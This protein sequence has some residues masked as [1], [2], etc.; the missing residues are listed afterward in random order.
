MSFLLFPDFLSGINLLG[1]CRVN[2][3][4][5]TRSFSSFLGG[6]AGGGGLSELYNDLR[7]NV[8]NTCARLYK[9][10]GHNSVVY[11]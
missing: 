9:L 10:A 5:E 8:L 7:K 11:A 3:W 6:G 2:P 1:M 4:V